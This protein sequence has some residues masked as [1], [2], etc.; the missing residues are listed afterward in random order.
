MISFV[1]R[2]HFLVTAEYLKM[3]GGDYGILIRQQRHSP[4]GI[5]SGRSLSE[6]ALS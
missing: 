4:T 5:Y 6:V 3:Q 1:V 2:Y